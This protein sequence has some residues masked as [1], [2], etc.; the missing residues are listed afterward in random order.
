MPHQSGE[1]TPMCSNHQDGSYPTTRGKFEDEGNIIR[2]NQLHMAIPKNNFYVYTTGF[3]PERTRPN[4]D[5]HGM[6]KGARDGK[7]FENYLGSRIDSL[8]PDWS[9]DIP[10][11]PN[12]HFV[13]EYFFYMPS[14]TFNDDE[15]QYLLFWNHEEAIATESGVEYLSPP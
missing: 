6:M 4:M 7:E 9:K 14:P 11:P 15:D 10:L 13:L 8:G 1:C 2:D 5:A 12:H 3:D